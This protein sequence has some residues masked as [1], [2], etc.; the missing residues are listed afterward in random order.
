MRLRAS[1][2]RLIVK[3]NEN[4]NEEDG[5]LTEE[6]NDQWGTILDIGPPM[7]D[8]SDNEG[9]HIINFKVGDEV[10]IAGKG[11]DTEGLKIMWIHDVPCWRRSGSNKT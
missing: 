1:I 8:V 9:N 10:L 3:P 6:K 2:G 7:P 11:I 5:F 4:T